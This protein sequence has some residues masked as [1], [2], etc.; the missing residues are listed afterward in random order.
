MFPILPMA[1]RFSARTKEWEWLSNLSA[2]GFELDT[3]K[4][5]SVEHYYQAQKFKGQ[6]E[7]DLIREKKTGFEALKE[8]KKQGLTP[9]EDWEE[10]RLSIM[11]TALNAKFQ[12]NRKLRTQLLQ[13]G[14]EELI[15]ASSSD[16]FWGQDTEG[17]GENYLGQMLMDIRTTLAS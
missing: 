3:L 10:M 12:Q 1:I 15:H 4:W 13:T 6:R 9:R 7:F 11:R 16:L 14:N 17:N 5:R 2:Y 8:A